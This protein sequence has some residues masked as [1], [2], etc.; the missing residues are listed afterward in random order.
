MGGSALDVETRRLATPQFTTA[1]Q[2]VGRLLESVLSAGKF[3]A[4]NFIPEKKTHGD[5]DILVCPERR[6]EEVRAGIKEKVN[7]TETYQN[8]PSLSM[9]VH[10]KGL[11]PFQL[12]LIEVPRKEWEMTKVFFD[13]ND[14]GNLLGK[15]ARYH[16]YKLGFQG[17]R[18]EYWYDLDRSVKLGEYVLTRDPKEALQFLGYDYESHRAGFQTFEEMFEYAL[19][20]EKAVSLAFMS[21]QLTASQRQRDVKRDVYQQFMEWLETQRPF[22]QLPRPGYSTALDKA[23][24]AFPEAN[25]RDQISEDKKGVRSRRAAHDVFNGGQLYRKGLDGPEIGDVLDEVKSRVDDYDEWRLQEGREDCLS[26][27]MKVRDEL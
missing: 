7:A 9:D 10:L 11:P 3:R 27:A 17:L 5:M 16:R 24:E 22:D 18:M 21:A 20:S 25:L 1:Q 2:R 4:L 19:S 15:V 13:W 6:W 23:A 14:L 26:F 12:D 8:G